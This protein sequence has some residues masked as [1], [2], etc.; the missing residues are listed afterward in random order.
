MALREE[1]EEEELLS[2]DELEE[3]DDDTEAEERR[4][5]VVRRA[6][7]LLD[8]SVAA[9]LSAKAFSAAALAIATESRPQTRSWKSFISVLMRFCS[10]TRAESVSQ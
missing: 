9:M 6:L 3:E 1:R 7:R 8:F 10:F 4:L 5:V 2:L